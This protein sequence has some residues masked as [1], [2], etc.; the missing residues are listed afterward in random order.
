MWYI[1]RYL[2]IY[3]NTCYFSEAKCKWCCS[4]WGCC[5]SQKALKQVTREKAFI[6]VVASSFG[7][8]MV[9]RLWWAPNCQHSKP[10]WYRHNALLSKLSSEFK[11]KS[12]DFENIREPTCTSSAIEQ[13]DS[14]HNLKIR[15]DPVYCLLFVPETTCSNIKTCHQTA[16]PEK[17]LRA[18]Q[19]KCVSTHTTGFHNRLLKKA[20]S[21]LTD[22]FPHYY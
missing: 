18:A 21:D 5:I 16:I 12:I 19:L 9:C 17:S 13:V 4:F 7:C 6:R 20:N 22:Q 14:P 15:D 10:P 1:I 8:L 3:R 2:A 11:S